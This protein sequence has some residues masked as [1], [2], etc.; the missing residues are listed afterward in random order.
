VT[1]TLPPATPGH[2]ATR[3]RYPAELERTWQPAGAPAVRI[4]P[5]R[6]DDLDLERDFV[7]GLSPATLYLRLQYSATQPSERDLVR[8][9]D[10]DYHDQLA[11]AALTGHAAESTAG[12]AIVGVARYARLGNSRTAEC[13]IVVADA[14]QGMGLGSEL[15]RSLAMAARERDIDDL[16]G[17]AL[18]ENQ[19]IVDWAR[20]F[21]FAF[22]TEPNSG[23]LV[24][25][26]LH[27]RDVS[28][29]VK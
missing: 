5:L 22:R 29:D 26:T 15:M 27:L 20:R 11:V 10:L 1:R 7:K 18:A 2:A 4:R 28:P 24:K 13:A 17:T 8:L 3:G 21:G 25:V 16:E 23:G 19:R 14:W 12:P 9:L 6:P